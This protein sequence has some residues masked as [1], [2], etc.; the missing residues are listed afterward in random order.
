M[1]WEDI[2]RKKIPELISKVIQRTATMFCLVYAVKSVPIVIVSVITNTQPIFT[3]IF[4]YI[5]LNERITRVETI[6]LLTSFVGVY[7]LVNYTSIDS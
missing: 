1:L 3:A 2:P 5:L 4:G 7:L 6:S